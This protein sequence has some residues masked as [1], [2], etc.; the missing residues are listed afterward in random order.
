M[1]ENAHARKSALP[2][3]LKISFFHVFRAAIESILLYGAEG[4]TI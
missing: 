2:D 3:S 4:W 1:H